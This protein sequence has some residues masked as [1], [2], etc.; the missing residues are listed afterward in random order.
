MRLETRTVAAPS[1]DAVKMEDR[2]RP[3]A[4][5]SAPPAKRQAVTV[6]GARSH[7]DADLPWKD[8]I[9]AFQ[10]DAILR[11]MREYKREKT[12]VEAQLNELERS[13]KYHDDHLRTMDAWF[14]QLVDEI[15]LLSG[16]KLETL[17]ADSSANSSVPATLLFQDSETFKKHLSTRKEK[18]LSSLSGLFAKY[19]PSSPEVAELQQ[20]LSKLLALEK[21]HVVQ[22]QRVRTEKEQLSDRLDTATHRY[23]VAEK[24]IDRLKSQQVQKLEQQAVASSTVKEETPTATNGVEPSNGKAISPAPVSEEVETARNQAVAEAAKRKEQL[25]QVEQENKKLTEEVTSLKV[26]FSLLSDDDY[27]KT[28]LF[29]ALKSQHED[30]IKRINNLEA[31]NIQLREEAQKYQAERTAY[32]IKIDDEARSSLAESESAVS[33]AEANLARIRAARDDLLAKNNL[34]E[35][36]RKNSEAST[37]QSK[38]LVSAVES[39]IAALESECERLRLQIAENQ[40]SADDTAPAVSELTLEESQKKT[41]NLETQLK[42]LSGE[43]PSME[44]AWKKAQSVANKKVIDTVAWEENIAR[45]NADKAKADQKYFAAMKVKTELEMQ[46]RALRL[47]TTKSTEVVSQLKEADALSRNLVDKLEK[48]TAEMRSQMDELSLQHRQLQ[49]K[50]SENAIISEG[51]VSQIAEL[52]K[53]LEA[54]DAS[55][56]A[57]K[58]AQREAETERESLTAQV[59]GL[60]K[61]VQTWKK[62]STGD[63]SSETATMEQMIQCQICK[64]HLKNTVIKTC[65]HLFCDQCVQDRLTNRAR[66]CPNCGKAFGSNDTMRVHL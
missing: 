15:K 33:Q 55:C 46:V 38:E 11:Q 63:Q 29:K 35:S 57:A 13:S 65:G 47:Q 17:S 60:K 37:E 3:S 54:K 22:L 16:E 18:I 12:T 28:D 51:H 42:L 20:Q 62:K 31:T 5:D 21:D 44:A 48:Q 4:D 40:T 56:L 53:V 6:N 64:S 49:Q 66:K 1:L 61:Q 23:L 32:R 19:P 9:E 10:K 50:V 30:V 58:Q 43:L 36:S 45:A 25:E 41:K 27:A 7:P 14:D 39:R 8:D 2:K 24:K 52:K 34:L 26:K 59:T